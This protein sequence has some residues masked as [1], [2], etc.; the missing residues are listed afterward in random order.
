MLP[1]IPGRAHDS[2]YT[3][4]NS[5]RTTEKTDMGA[6]MINGLRIVGMRETT[7]FAARASGR[8]R[9]VVTGKEVL[10]SPELELEVPLKEACDFSDVCIKRTQRVNISNA[11]QR[12]W[13]TANCNLFEIRMVLASNGGTGCH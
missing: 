11:G 8:D 3:S 13:L 7:T 5:S 9:P 6:E 1:S 2:T 12:S 4:T 10:Y